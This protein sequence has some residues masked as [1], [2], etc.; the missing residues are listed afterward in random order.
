MIFAITSIFMI[1]GFFAG[2]NMN[3]HACCAT[4]LTVGG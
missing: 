4:P 1:A 3:A 2:K